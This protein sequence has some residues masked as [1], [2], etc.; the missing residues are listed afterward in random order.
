MDTSN[1]ERECMSHH[2]M[3][4]R[5]VEFQL[6]MKKNSGC[7]VS[8]YRRWETPFKTAERIICREKLMAD[9]PAS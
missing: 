6:G 5:K 4:Y 2:L 1:L 9:F 7:F 8:N 3:Q